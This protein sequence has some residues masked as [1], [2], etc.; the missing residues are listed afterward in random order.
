MFL[1]LL[2]NLELFFWPVHANLKKGD[3]VDIKGVGTVQKRMLPNVTTAK[4][5]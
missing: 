2:G 5:E 1:G 3:T 4:L